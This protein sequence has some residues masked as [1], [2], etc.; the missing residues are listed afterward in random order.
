VLS[1]KFSGVAYSP[2]SRQ[3]LP[4]FQNSILFRLNIHS[5]VNLRTWLICMSR[6]IIIHLNVNEKERARKNYILGQREYQLVD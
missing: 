3:L 4:P 2:P 5:L 6:F 1:V